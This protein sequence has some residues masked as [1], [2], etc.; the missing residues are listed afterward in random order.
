MPGL[1][2]FSDFQQATRDVKLT[3]PE[4]LLNEATRHSYVVN[5]MLRGRDASEVFRGGSK[6]VERLMVDHNHSFRT[7]KPN[8]ELNPSAADTMRSINFPWRFTVGGYSW[9]DNEILLNHG[10]P[11]KYVDLKFDYEQQAMTSIIEGIEDLLWAVPN[12]A[13]MEATGGD[14]PYSIPCYLTEGGLAPWVGTLAGLDP[15]VE[16]IW[17]NQSGTYNRTNVRSPDASD[18]IF[19]AF[20]KMLRLVKFERLNAGQFTKYWEDDNLRKMRIFC[21]GNG[22]DIFKELMRQK[23]NRLVAVDSKN[24]SD[25]AYPDPRFDGY[26]IEWKEALDT[27][28]LYG[29]T[30][31]SATKNADGSAAADCPRFYFPNMKYLMTTFHEQ[32]YFDQKMVDGGARQPFTHVMW[33]DTYYNLVCRSRRRQGIVYPV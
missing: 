8:D 33:I 22:L 27:A 1:D 28:K 14:T 30:T 25:P 21:N 15:N 26:P 24:A 20:D 31:T 13:A 16:T 19:A 6:L 10:D 32:K 17:R 12:S 7:Y 5:E 18:G 2:K 4:E 11:N 9:N 29:S 23:N 3:G